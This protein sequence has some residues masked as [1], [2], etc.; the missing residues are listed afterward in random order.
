MDFSSPIRISAE[1]P[2]SESGAARARAMAGLGEPGG[3]FPPSPGSVE[4]R[5]LCARWRAGLGA[6]DTAH[7]AGHASRRF[8]S[9][10]RERV[11][12]STP[13]D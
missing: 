3:L 13:L 7:P 1:R 11:T 9:A 12:V 5:P 4:A 8:A 10:C 2:L 6:C